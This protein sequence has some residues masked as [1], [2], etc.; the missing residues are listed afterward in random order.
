MNKTSVAVGLS[1]VALVVAAIALISV[2]KIGPVQ[3]PQRSQIIDIYTDTTTGRCVVLPQE[4]SL[5]PGENLYFHSDDNLEYYV[6][7]DSTTCGDPAKAVKIPAPGSSDGNSSDVPR[8]S[9]SSSSKL[10]KFAV[11][12]SQNQACTSRGGM[13]PTIGIRIRP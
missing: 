11:C 6:Y 12:N 5:Y 7:L 9:S 13:N 10:V 4:P 2:V 1:L 8:P 3:A